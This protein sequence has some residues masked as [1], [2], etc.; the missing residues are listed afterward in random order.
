MD[1]LAR[2]YVQTGNNI[3][4]SYT[5]KVEKN[6]SRFTSQGKPKAQEADSIKD[7]EHIK[8]I[9][10]YFLK[11]DPPY[12]YRNYT[13]FTLGIM[14][15]LRVSDLMRIT[16]GDLMYPNGTFKKRL[17]ITEKKTCK[18]NYPE[19]SQAIQDVV[20]EYIKKVPERFTLLSNPLFF[21]DKG[22]YLS[23]PS[24]FRILKKAQRDLNLPYNIGTHSLRKTFAYWIIHNNKD[25]PMALFA[26]QKM[27]NHSDQRVTFRYAGILQDETDEMYQSIG[28]LFISK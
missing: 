11:Q 19:I 10:E 12:S 6:L 9:Q 1:N 27:L 15:G 5:K 21:S 18:T 20:V 22:G 28:N 24:I 7:L 14:L 25:N 23:E 16:L 8:L 4:I 17:V 26:L 2:S 13:L 3:E